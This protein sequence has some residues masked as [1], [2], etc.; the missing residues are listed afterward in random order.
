MLLLFATSAS[1]AVVYIVSAIVDAALSPL[2]AIT[3]TYLYFDL[4]IRAEY[5]DREL[6]H[7]DVLPAEA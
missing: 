7:V 2:V 4:R 1:F 3:T 6:A 5:A